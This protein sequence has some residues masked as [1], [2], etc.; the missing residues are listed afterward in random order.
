VGDRHRPTSSA[1]PR[2][3][4]RRPRRARTS[5]SGMKLSDREHTA[6]IVDF[7][8]N[9]LASA[10]VP[11]ENAPGNETPQRSLPRRTALLDARHSARPACLAARRCR[12]WGSG[13]RASSTTSS[14]HVHLVLH[15][16]RPQGVDLA[17]AATRTRS[18]LTVTDRQRRQP[19]GTGRAVVRRGPRHGPTSLSS[20]SSTGS[21]WGLSST[22][23]CYRGAQ[24]LGHGTWPHQGPA[25]RRALP[26]RAARVP[27]GLRR[28]LR[29]RARGGG[30]A[31]LDAQ[32]C[33]V[34]TTSCS[35]ASTT[36]PRPATPPRGRSSAAPGRY[37]AVGLANVVNLFDPSLIILSGERMRYDYLYA[38]D[39]LA[40]MDSLVLATGKASPAAHRGARLGRPALGPRRGSARACRP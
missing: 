17:H 13:C 24:G 36:M 3:G 35:K 29:A 23:A 30:G 6:V 27:R 12:R 8:G 5:S 2:R 40:E 33:A 15:P 7:A 19:R 21:A 34:G 18:A 25:R 9:L 11:I 28:R 10:S 14:G 22:I 16:R 31:Q 37:L 20:R 1:G 4:A 38:D 26:L 32:G 39:T